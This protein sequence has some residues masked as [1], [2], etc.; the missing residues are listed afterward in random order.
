MLTPVV[1]LWLW[2]GNPTMSCHN[3]WQANWRALSTASSG[4][5]QSAQSI[6]GLRWVCLGGNSGGGGV[7]FCVALNICGF[8]LLQ[9]FDDGC[10]VPASGCPLSPTPPHRLAVLTLP[11]T[12]LIVRNRVE[13]WS[14][15]GWSAKCGWVVRSFTVLVD[16]PTTH[17]H[18][19]WLNYQMR[20][21]VIMRIMRLDKRY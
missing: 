5:T 19:H 2:V 10:R 14:A 6:C 16:A 18:T 11:A 15:S 12:C 9:Q 7:D 20:L 3:R 1:A 13:S 17:K 21:F 8:A 4:S